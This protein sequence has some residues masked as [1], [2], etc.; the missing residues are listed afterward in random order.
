MPVAKLANRNK[1]SD[2]RAKSLDESIAAIVAESL[3][4]VLLV[5]ERNGADKKG[6]VVKRHLVKS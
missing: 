5:S 2:P 6:D 4:A 1:T 3:R